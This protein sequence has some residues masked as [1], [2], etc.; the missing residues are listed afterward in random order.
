MTEL[1]TP[2]SVQ[3]GPAPLPAPRGWRVISGWW[4]WA[5]R[6][7]T[8]MRT[9][10]VLLFML[11]LASVPGSVIPQQGI[12]PAAVAQYYAAHPALAPIMARLSL[13]NVFAAPWFA[14]I[15]LLLFL[16]LAGCVLPRTFRLVGSAR[17]LPPR[18]PRNLA[19]L[20]LA[21]SYRTA[22][23]PA[24]A[25]ESAAGLLSGKRFR[26]R[27][28]EGWVAAE[29]GYLREVGN[30]LFHIALLALLGSVAVGGIFGYKADRLLVSGQSFGNTVTALDQFRPGRLVT[31]G[32]LQPF[33]ITLDNFVAHYV[34]SGSTRGEPSSFDA[35]LLYSDRP[36]APEHRYLLQ[37]NHP[38]QV[39][40]VRV[41]LIGHGYAPV[42]RITDG[43][44]RVVFDSPV[45][46][47]PVE[48]S[49]LTS[50][51]VIKVPDADPDQLGF[52]GVFLPT[53]IDINGRLQSAFPAALLPRVSLVSYAGNLGLNSGPS[54]SVYQLVTTHMRRLPILPRPLAPGQSMKLP[55]H[56]G[57]LTFTGYRQW[58]SLAITYDPGQLP[59]LISGILAIA[60]LL[61]SFAVRRRRVFVRAA[62]A[63][64]GTTVV[65]L[66]GLARSDAAGGFETEFASLT[67]E[68]TQSQDGS[69]L[70]GPAG[71]AA[72]GPAS[73]DAA[74]AFDS[75]AAPGRDS[76]VVG[77]PPANGDHPSPDIGGEPSGP[78]TDSEPSLRHDEGE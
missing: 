46:F 21:A 77:E 30:L 57:T 1:R 25:L 38:L 78:R 71:R 13:F 34:T 73:R 48:Q 2:P 26:L 31:P 16:S 69:Q 74:A 43:A 42:F 28:G 11:A 54:Q 7:L 44:G 27:T 61:L 18:A 33:S 6:Q 15:Y 56:A 37:V 24:E 51:G 20:P 75:P 65:Y 19:R 68:I 9:A 32:D 36:G 41:Y 5:W 39:D 62:A 47:I 45:P 52:A 64:D 49:G 4:R 55:G 8:S 10:L 76:A 29:K 67:G 60:G 66:G 50:E 3:A 40:G 14:A 22:L 58:A 63:A 17:Q 59:A 72:E 35:S 53:A 23:T 12:D 70:T